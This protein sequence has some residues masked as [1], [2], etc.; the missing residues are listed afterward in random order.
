MID[1]WS[2]PDTTNFSGFSRY[3]LMKDFSRTR[4]GSST[5]ELTSLLRPMFL[6]PFV[7]PLGS[8]RC[9]TIDAQF[10]LSRTLNTEQLCQTYVDT[11]TQ[12]GPGFVVEMY[13]I[14]KMMCITEKIVKRVLLEPR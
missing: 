14:L 13:P 6:S 2:R 12:K 7:N 11:D 8:S 1:G 5:V 3:V 10:A 4:E 9:L